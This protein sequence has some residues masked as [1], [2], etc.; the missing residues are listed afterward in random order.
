MSGNI[1]VVGVNLEKGSG[2][3][4][5]GRLDSYYNVVLLNLRKV[6]FEDQTFLFRNSMASEDSGKIL[7]RQATRYQNSHRCANNPLTLPNFTKARYSG[8]LRAV[9]K[10]S[11]LTYLKII[12]SVFSTRKLKRFR[13]AILEKEVRHHAQHIQSEII[14]L[15]SKAS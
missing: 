3:S 5:L 11:K 15:F 8:I 6:T 13:E 12:P 2:E 7:G 4:L 9:C 14:T 1:W 10:A